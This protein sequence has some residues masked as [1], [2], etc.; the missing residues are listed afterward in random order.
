MRVVVILSVIAGFAGLP[1]ASAFLA[2]PANGIWASLCSGQPPI[3]IDFGSGENDKPPQPI[4]S[5]ACHAVCC[6]RDDTPTE[7]HGTG[8][9]VPD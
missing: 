5:K 8:D 2:S 3:W 4:H 1:I 7:G 9:N 6:K